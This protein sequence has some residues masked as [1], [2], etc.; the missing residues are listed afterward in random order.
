MLNQSIE[1]L[2]Y[3]IAAAIK[4]ITSPIKP[5]IAFIEGHGELDRYHTADLTMTLED[6]YDVDR[7]SL[8]GNLNALSERYGSDTNSIYMMNKYKLLIIAKPDS[9]FSEKDKYLIDQHIMHGGKVL[10][11]IDQVKAEM[12]SLNSKNNHVFM[13]LGNNLNLDDQ[14]FKYGVRINKDLIQ[15]IQSAPIPVVTGMIGNQTKTDLFP[16]NFFPLF[17]QQNKHP[18]WLSL[19]LRKNNTIEEMYR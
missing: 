17:L 10:W 16:W 15:D 14:L 1:A 7:V 4:K 2:E 19:N 13:A 11:V 6:Y 12:D 5:N 18:T 3:E 8:N 9:A